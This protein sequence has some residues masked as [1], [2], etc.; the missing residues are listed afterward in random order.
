MGEVIALSVSSSKSGF[1]KQLKIFTSVLVKIKNRS[2]KIYKIE[3]L[4]GRVVVEQSCSFEDIFA[5]IDNYASVL[6]SPDSF[7]SHEWEVEEFLSSKNALKFF[8]DNFNYSKYFK[9]KSLIE[10]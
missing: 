4:L 1:F 10:K 6:N 3:L 2:E 5:A 9:K 7:F 8:P